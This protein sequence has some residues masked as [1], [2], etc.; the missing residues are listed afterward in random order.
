ML[1][2]VQATYSL[3]T[4]HKK[5]LYGKGNYELIK[6]DIHLT[7]GITAVFVNIDML[8]SLQLATLQQE[9]NLPVY[10]RC[11]QLDVIS[12]FNSYPSEGNFK[13]IWKETNTTAAC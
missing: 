11:E 2:F 9:W 6:K 3:K 4:F 10:D 8:T 1:C 12:V 13:D 7:K 5:Y